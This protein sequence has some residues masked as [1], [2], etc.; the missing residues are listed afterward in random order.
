MDVRDHLGVAGVDGGAGVEAHLLLTA[1]ARQVGVPAGAR[2][3]G[4]VDAVALAEVHLELLPVGDD[5]VVDD[6]RGALEVRIGVRVDRD[7][8]RAD[9]RA[10]TD[11]GAGRA[12]W[13][14]KKK[15]AESV[16][17]RSMFQ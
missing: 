9:E 14:A 12:A 1:E 11:A 7:A 2:P 5:E 17:W 15:P 4:R 8:E 10:G 3:V 6:R 16:P 13:V